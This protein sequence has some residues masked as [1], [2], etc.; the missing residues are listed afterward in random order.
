M[1]SLEEELRACE[2]QIRELESKKAL[3]NEAVKTDF[4]NARGSMEKRLDHLE[5]HGW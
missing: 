2:E 1:A 4:Q 5:T 3:K